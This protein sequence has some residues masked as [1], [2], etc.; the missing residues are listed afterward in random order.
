MLTINTRKK[1]IKVNGQ[2]ARSTC[3][4][5]VHKHMLKPI[6]NKIR[7]IYNLKNNSWNDHSHHLIKILG[8]NTFNP[9]IAKVKVEILTFETVSL[10]TPLQ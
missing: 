9:I 8:T 4:L 3:I 7:Q 2:S 1:Q 10:G 6:A 5:N